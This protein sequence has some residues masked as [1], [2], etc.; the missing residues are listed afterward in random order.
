[1]EEVSSIVNNLEGVIRELK[2][3]DE[4]PHSVDDTLIDRLIDSIQTTGTVHSFF[5]GVQ[6]GLLQKMDSLI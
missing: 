1:M 5:C 3:V 6:C 2:G 4:L